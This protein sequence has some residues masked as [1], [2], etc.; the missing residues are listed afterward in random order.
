MAK[1]ARET[2]RRATAHT[3]MIVQMALDGIITFSRQ[4]LLIRMLNPA[5]E[6]IFGYREVQMVG[7]PMQVL[8][9][10]SSGGDISLLA[11]T[12][13]IGE[14]AA[15][16][17]RRE[18]SGRRSDGSTF[19]VEV[20]FTEARL[21]SESFFIGTFRDITERKQAE[22]EMIGAKDAA[23]SANR[24]KSSFLA[25]MSHELRT[26][27]NAIIGYSEMLREEAEDAG[28]G[29]LVPDLEKIR[30]AG[31]QLLELINNI[32][33]LSKIEAGRMD[34]YYERFIVHTLVAE[35]VSIITPLMERNHN[36]LVVE[37]DPGVEIM[38][39]DLTKVRQVLLNLLSNASKF[40]E[41]GTVTLRVQLIADCRLQIAD[42]RPDAA[43]SAINNLP[44][45]IIFEVTDTGIGMSEAQMAGLF[46][47]F[48]QADAST[49]RTYG[50]TGLGLAISRRFCQMMGGDITVK[51]E[52]GVGS[53]FLVSLPL[54]LPLVPG[55]VLEPLA[56]GALPVASSQAAVLVI[57][58][59][60]A[61]RELIRR[62]LGREGIRVMLASSGPEGLALARAVRPAVIT[63][64]VM[65]P[66][67]DGWA[68]LSEIKADADLHDV[69]VIMMTMMDDRQRGFAL[70]AADYLMK[71]VDRARLLGVVNTHR[72]V[73]DVDANILIV[74][75]DLTTREML[76]RM[77]E[78]EGWIVSEADNGEMALGRVAERRPDLILLDLM[79][80]KMDGFEV[81]SALRSTAL[82]RTIPIVVLTAMDLS[83][84]D[85]LRLNG[86]VERVLQKGSYA[87]EDLLGDLRGLVLRYMGQ[88]DKGV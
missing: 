45:A 14:M 40:S 43:Q 37:L 7:Q 50:G 46:K 84:T 13:L 30:T 25:N 42:V 21:G 65:M 26:P 85:R 5:A 81:I 11:A 23:E 1:S 67:M 75:D 29:D 88:P 73:A 56:D 19:P 32:L 48:S 39:A 62:T 59:D 38:N 61:A 24:A 6:A 20:M 55:H 77:L 57:D 54:G 58:D 71:P 17:G 44:S 15:T 87:H 34:L 27:L 9:S 12:A 78:R 49:T 47:E 31:K 83:T 10:D 82:W 63:L 66:E 52:S 69:P 86:Y 28:S 22:S 60:P 2:L 64:D 80:P 3:R 70:G 76:R 36:R 33:D 68:V 41:S 79:M 51:S 4:G 35:V 16:A 18:I 8:L 72:S 74:E 53:T